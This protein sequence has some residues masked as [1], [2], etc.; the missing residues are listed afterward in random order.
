MKLYFPEITF[1]AAHYIPGHP[2]CGT[3]HGHT[4]FIRNLTISIDKTLWAEYGISIDFSEVKRYFKE[5]WDHKFIA[6]LEDADKWIEEYNNAKKENVPNQ[7]IERA[8]KR[9]T[10]ELKDAAEISEVTYEGYG[11]GGIAVIVE[12]LTDNKN[13]TLTNVR[14]AFNKKGGNLGGSGSVAWMFDRKGVITVT[15]ETNTD[16]IELAAIEAGAEDIKTDGNLVEIHTSP[17]DLNNV[18]E[19][20]KNK[21]IEA[22]NAEILLVPKDVMKIEDEVAAKKILDFIDALEDDP[23]V[24]NVSS[25]FDIKDELMDKMA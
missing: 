25:N 16:E 8:I 19:K 18:N 13:R 7:N 17:N 23:D 4:Y 5:V 3:P 22:E 11:P 12:C 1:E 6:P 20:L 21:G 15:A 2:T 24:T 9:G 10:G 14:T